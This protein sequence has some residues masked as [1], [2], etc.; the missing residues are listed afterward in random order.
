M[1]PVERKKYQVLMY[2]LIGVNIKYVVTPSR[3]KA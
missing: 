3:K 2:W 1:T